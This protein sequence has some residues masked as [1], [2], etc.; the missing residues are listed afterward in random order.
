M[1]LTDT[2][3]R[4]AMLEAARR[5]NPKQAN[6]VNMVRDFAGTTSEVLAKGPPVSGQAAS[7]LCLAIEA[8]LQEVDGE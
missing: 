8:M 7:Y 5:T 1:A 4:E 3:V 6:R 2:R